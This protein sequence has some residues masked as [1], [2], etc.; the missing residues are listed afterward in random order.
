MNNEIFERTRE[1]LASATGHGP[2]EIA[3]ESQLE[4]NLGV[5]LEEDF[6]RL[7]AMI[8]QEFEVELDEDHLLNELEKA[9]NT[10]EQ[11][12][13]LIEEEVELG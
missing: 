4:A 5:D 8:S 9:D 3:P 1:L 2:E 7:I 13:K 10:V 11:L 6:P 12:A